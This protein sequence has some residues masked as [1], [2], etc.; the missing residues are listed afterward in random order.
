[1]KSLLSI[2]AVSIAF[3]ASSQAQPPAPAPVPEGEIPGREI[4]APT[5]QGY[6]GQDQ[7][8]ATGE[9]MELFQR[10]KVEDV[11]NIHPRA[12]PKIIVVPD[13][14]ARS[15]FCKRC[16][17]PSVAIKIYVPPYACKDL[18]IK[19]YGREHKYD[20]DDYKVEIEVKRDYVK[21]DYD[22]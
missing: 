7:Q 12:V 10:V 1:M 4:P 19:D 14:C 3:V 5:L 20:Y 22:D 2:I 21:V 13:P 15:K 16:S 8:G 9:V 6:Q 17:P 18:E 11:D